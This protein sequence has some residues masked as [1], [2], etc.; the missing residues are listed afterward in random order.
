MNRKTP[1]TP[2]QGTTTS[3]VAHKTSIVSLQFRRGFECAAAHYS[4]NKTPLSSR[5]GQCAHVRAVSEQL[6]TRA[7][8][9]AA[10]DK[11]PWVGGQCATVHSWSLGPVKAHTTGP[12]VRSCALPKREFREPQDGN[13]ARHGDCGVRRC[14][15]TLPGVGAVQAW[16][17][18]RSRALFGG[19]TRAQLRTAPGPIPPATHQPPPSRPGRHRPA[20]WNHQKRGTTRTHHTACTGCPSSYSVIHV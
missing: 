15:Q 16:C 2:G 14:V 9:P 10:K 3:G 12:S 19:R 20:G 6:R 8:L 7:E 17:R 11:H 18:V 1:A 4:E 13:D 5:S